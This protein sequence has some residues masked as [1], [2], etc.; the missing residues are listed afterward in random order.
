MNTFPEKIQ[1]FLELKVI[2]VTGVSSTR[3]D[4]ANFIYQKF[5]DSDYE[6][7]PINPSVSSVEGVECYPDISSTPN[8]PEGV[9]IASPPSSA[10]SIIEECIS[11]G[12]QHVWF[13]SSINKGSLD[14]KAAEFGEEKGL[15]I[16]RT[17]CPM[18]YIPPIDFG[19]KCIKWVLKL[20]GK[21]PKK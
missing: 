19:H 1:K 8:Q 18:M 2:A 20:T 14:E 15:N 11:L 10:K 6:V 13:H 21:I 12:I 17:G 16:I 4:A 7:F 9:L 3:P 5:R